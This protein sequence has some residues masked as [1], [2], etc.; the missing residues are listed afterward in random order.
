MQKLI[1]VMK[2]FEFNE[3]DEAVKER[4]RND[5]YYIECNMINQTL[6]ENFYCWLL[7]RHPDLKVRVYDEDVSAILLTEWNVGYPRDYVQI[8]LNDGLSHEVFAEFLGLPTGECFELHNHE[9]DTE[10]V[11]QRDEDNSYCLGKVE[12]RFDELL[13]EIKKWVSA[14]YDFDGDEI[15]AHLHEYQ[16]LENGE[17][18]D[19]EMES[20]ASIRPVTLNDDA[21]GHEITLYQISGEL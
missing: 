8:N 15:D 6:E 3:L 20:Y 7:K 1:V 17:V 18:F 12:D 10:I 2:V 13:A 19:G 11:M 14:Q 16:Y 21:T 4:V 9:G 5:W